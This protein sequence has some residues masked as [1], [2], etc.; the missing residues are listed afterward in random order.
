MDNLEKVE[1]LREKTGVTY[2][3]AKQALEACSYDLLDAI[4]YLEKLGKVKGPEISSYTTDSTQKS[5]S[6]F[7]QAQQTYNKDCCK[8]TLGQMM[9]RFFKWCGN[10]LKKSVECKFIVSRR[11]SNIINVPVLLLV[12]ALICAFWVVIPLLIVGLFCECRYRFEGIDDITV[13]L[14][15]ACD[16]VAESVDSFKSDVNNK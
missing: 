1:K 16:K 12:I 15:D 2:E 3:E 7:E 4:I 14:N 5:T 13:N 9:D 11:G 10:V 8:V 6:E